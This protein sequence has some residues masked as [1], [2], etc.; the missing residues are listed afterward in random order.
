MS[1]KDFTQEFQ[2]LEICNLGPDSL[3]E[4]ELSNQK[5]WEMSKENGAWVRNVSAGGC[6]NNLG[7]CGESSVDLNEYC[8]GK[9]F[10]PSYRFAVIYFQ[11]IGIFYLRCSTVIIK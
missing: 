11:K 7:G 3:D 8:C 2:K 4:E 9:E 10:C 5:R 1:F 6:R